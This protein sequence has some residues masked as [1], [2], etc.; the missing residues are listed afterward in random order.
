[1][2]I[3]LLNL[4]FNFQDSTWFTSSIPDK[5][6]DIKYICC[7]PN[8]YYFAACSNEGIHVWDAQS[9]KLMQKLALE[10]ALHQNN[11]SLTQCSFFTSDNKNTY[12]IAGSNDGFII[13]WKKESLI[14]LFKTEIYA[15]VQ[16]S[17]TCIISPYIDKDMNVMYGAG[18][19]VFLQTYTNLRLGSGLHHKDNPQLH[20]G[21]ATKSCFLP[22]TNK[23]ITCGNR[24]LYLWD[25]PTST[26]LESRTDIVFGSL[27]RLS[28]DGN[29]FLTFG[30]GA[31]I[32]VW[33]SHCLKCL[34]T[35]KNSNLLLD[36]QCKE[37]LTLWN[38]SL[39]HFQQWIGGRW[40]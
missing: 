14:E 39:C 19:I 13:S 30:D 29:H 2:C 12:I 10:S 4:H 21:I 15:K 1:M 16:G 37:P 3:N 24:S 28:N 36:S 6:D 25:V 40:Y 9:L 7:S 27:I 11:A 20:P 38:L 35:I 8:G 23:A 5:E 17:T 22:G 33:D 18:N 32:Q 34:S 26:M 31:H